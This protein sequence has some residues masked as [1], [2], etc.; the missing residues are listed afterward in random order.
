MCGSIVAL[1]P[2]TTAVGFILGGIGGIF[3]LA[4]YSTCP[5]D[6]IK[7]ENPFVRVFLIGGVW[8]I[9]LSVWIVFC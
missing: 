2:F 9:P 1:L 5:K 4:A 7:L 8:L 6:A 3:T